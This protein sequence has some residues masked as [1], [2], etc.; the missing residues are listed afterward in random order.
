MSWGEVE[1]RREGGGGR[2]VS[3]S[4]QKQP[5]LTSFFL[6]SPA[7]KKNIPAKNDSRKLQRLRKESEEIKA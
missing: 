7:E 3:S 4:F 6:P 5:V 1:V 2:K